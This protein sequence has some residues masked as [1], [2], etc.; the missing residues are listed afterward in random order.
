[1]ELQLTEDALAL[2]RERGGRMALDFISP[3]G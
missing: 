2:L 1:M 3:V